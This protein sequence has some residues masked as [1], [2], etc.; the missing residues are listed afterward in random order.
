LHNA[1]TVAEERKGLLVAL[2]SMKEIGVF[3]LKFL[4]RLSDYLFVAATDCLIHLAGV[5]DVNGRNDCT[6]PYWKIA[7]K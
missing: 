1:R 5:E 4:N 3:A 6:T 2:S 7:L